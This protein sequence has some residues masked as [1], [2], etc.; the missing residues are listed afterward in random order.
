MP[1]EQ[2]GTSVVLSRATHDHMCILHSHCGCHVENE[3]EERERMCV[4]Q[5]GDLGSF[6][7]GL[8]GLQRDRGEVGCA[9]GMNHSSQ[10]QEHNKCNNS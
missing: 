3:L 7:T 1:G 10:S 4:D 8:K 2:Q 9:A 6:H 5:R